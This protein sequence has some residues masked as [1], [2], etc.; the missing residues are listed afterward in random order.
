MGFFLAQIVQA[1]GMSTFRTTLIAASTI[2][3]DP[4]TKV[5]ALSAAAFG[6][7][8]SMPVF[9]TFPTFFLSGAAAAGGIALINSIGN[10]VGSVRPHL[11]RRGSER[12]PAN[13]WRLGKRY[14]PG[15]CPI[16]DVARVNASLRRL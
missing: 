16:T 6:I 14:E 1:F 9:W 12:S 15:S 11:A 13:S 2:L 7:F 4:L 3:D 8:A 5:A 10:L